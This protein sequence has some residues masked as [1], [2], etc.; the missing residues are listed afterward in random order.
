MPAWKTHESRALPG[1][2][3]LRAPDP[4]PRNL[5]RPRATL[6]RKA[7]KAVVNFC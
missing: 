7:D 5:I 1:R 2:E 6:L 4:A 3:A